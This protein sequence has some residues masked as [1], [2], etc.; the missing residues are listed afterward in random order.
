[1]R[2]ELSMVRVAF[3][4]AI[5]ETKRMEG[6]DRD[7]YSIAALF[8]QE[9]PAYKLI[10]DAAKKVAAEEWGLKADEVLA[11]AKKKDDGKNYI[12]KDGDKKEYDGYPG[13][14]YISPN[15]K[16]R[17]Q[18]F[19]RDGSP[20]T[21]TDGVIYGGCYADVIVDVY[22]FAH[23]VGGKGIS[24]ELKGVRFR[25]HADAFGGGAPVT[26]EAFSELAADDI[27]L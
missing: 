2:V 24:S 26:P 20:L 8:P 25:K 3:T 11:L 12:L 14:Y 22:A 21:A 15:S 23:K 17:P 4:D 5:F 19:N 27:E 1:M 16:K 10:E 13:N 7:L 6:S 18:V 9:H